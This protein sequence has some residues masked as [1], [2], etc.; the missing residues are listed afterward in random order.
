VITFIS[1]VVIG[2]LVG[3]LYALVSVGLTLVYGVL[4]IVNFAHGEFMMLGM[5]AAYI[6]QTTWGLDPYVSWP[7]ATAFVAVFAWVSYI[8]I[9]KPTIEGAHVVQGFVTLGL[10]LVLQNVVLFIFTSH[11]VSTTTV[12][13]EGAFDFSGVR[14]PYQDLVSA[15]AAVA[16]T[17]G[18]WLWLHH[19]DFGRAVRA[20]AQNPL[21]SR[22][23]GIDDN[24]IYMW[25]FVLG[26][27]L[28]GLGGALFSP[29]YAIFPTVGFGIMLVAF[30]VVVLGGLGSL[31]GAFLGALIIGVV[32]A[33]TSYYLGPDARQVV[34]FLVFV[35]ILVLRP[36]GLLGIKGAELVGY[37]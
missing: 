24:T 12:I 36:N 31:P 6:M 21:A 10:S 11:V 27:A 37:R 3:C 34:Y 13:G 20:T 5:Y 4:R 26:T 19:T 18:L 9:I 17:V 32:E 8:F 22:L 35:G 28:A 14:V 7:L 23:Q 2:L 33:V 1:I 16:I 25:T 15:A 29:V 30:V